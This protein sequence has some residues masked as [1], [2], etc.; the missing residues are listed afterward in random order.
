MSLVHEIRTPASFTRQYID[1]ICPDLGT[2]SRKINVGLKDAPIAL[3]PDYPDTY[4]FSLA[5]TATDLRIRALFGPIVHSSI[6]GSHWLGRLEAPSHIGSDGT[7]FENPWNRTLKSERAIG[8]CLDNYYDKFIASLNP[9][10][11]VLDRADEDR[12]CRFCI[13]FARIDHYNRQLIWR[14]LFELADENVELMLERAAPAAMVE[15]IRMLAQRFCDRHTT[16]LGNVSDIHLGCTL[17]GSRD[18]FGA[19]F[20]LVADGTLWELK[21]KLKPKVST[22]NFRQVL[23]YWLLDYEDQFAIRAVS[24]DLTRQARTYQ[25]DIHRDLLSPNAR[26]MDTR[27]IR[28]AFE[29]GVKRE[30]QF[31]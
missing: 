31:R 26:K 24:I 17:A 22:E 6:A 10:Y 7:V 5:G 8:D 14:P 19:D 23:G 20:D 25:F 28:L 29:R 1:K 27:E 2:I 9:N 3:R 12:L 21:T 13:L 16:L 15:D 11:L 18:V 30:A 4:T